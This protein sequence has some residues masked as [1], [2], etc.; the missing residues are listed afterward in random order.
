[1]ANLIV[2]ERR[3]VMYCRWVGPGGIVRGNHIDTELA[4]LS[5]KSLIDRKVELDQ[6][7]IANIDYDID[8]A[9]QIYLVRGI[10]WYT[11]ET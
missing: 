5:I 7:K 10:V 1:M 6:P 3:H 11:S 9:S 4:H 2:R 8:N